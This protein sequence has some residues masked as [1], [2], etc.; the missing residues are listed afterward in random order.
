[1]PSRR[2]SIAKRK[3]S[4]APNLKTIYERS[5]SIERGERS[6]SLNSSRSNS[7]SSKSGRITLRRAP[8]VT[9]R[10]IEPII[11]PRKSFTRKLWKGLKKRVNFVFGYSR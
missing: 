8:E 10:E 2:T 1:M 4:I 11:R 5:S 3:A 6:A 9:F 7:N